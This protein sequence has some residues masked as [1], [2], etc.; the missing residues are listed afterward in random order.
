MYV[1]KK[2]FLTLILL[3][4]FLLSMLFFSYSG[5][6]KANGGR[7]KIVPV[8]LKNFLKVDDVG[9]S[10]KS[11]A[12]KDDNWLNFEATAY[13]VFG[14]TRTGV[15][16]HRGIIAVDP[17][18]IPLG[19]IVEIKAGD[20]SGIYTA[21]DTGTLIKGRIIDIYVP[22]FEEAIRFGRRKIKL[23]ILRKGWS[24]FEGDGRMMTRVKLSKK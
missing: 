7:E 9:K 17:R 2:L 8:N 19:S 3:N 11:V 6:R 15:W 1:N 18:I 13:C 12:E 4:L 21:M 14:I 20:Y 16:V 10:G 24:P 22:D 23:R 5:I